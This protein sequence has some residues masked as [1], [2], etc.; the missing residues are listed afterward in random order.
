[1][2]GTRNLQFSVRL[3]YLVAFCVHERRVAELASQRVTGGPA[4]R[5][6]VRQLHPLIAFFY[7]SA[8]ALCCSTY[9]LHAYSHTCMLDFLLILLLLLASR[10]NLIHYIYTIS[11]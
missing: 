11:G 4:G 9:R 8:S 7:S 2:L 3:S 10:L 5:R 6:A 1:M